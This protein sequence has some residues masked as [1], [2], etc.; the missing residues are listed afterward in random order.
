VLLKA[1]NGHRLSFALGWRNAG[2]TLSG[3]KQFFVPYRGHASAPDFLK[4]YN[5]RV[6]LFQKDVAGENLYK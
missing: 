4:F 2:L 5:H 3:D 1:I 6:T